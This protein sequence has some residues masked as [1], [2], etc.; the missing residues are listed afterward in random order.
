MDSPAPET[1]EF[2]LDAAISAL[3]GPARAT[4]KPDFTISHL[5]DLKKTAAIITVRIKSQDE[6]RISQNTLQQWDQLNTLLWTI[7]AV[8]EIT[9]SLR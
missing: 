8:E 1:P 5:K 3:V 9:P 7:A 2:D 6:R 4:L